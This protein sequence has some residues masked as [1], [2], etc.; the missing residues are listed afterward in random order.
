[1][2]K[3]LQMPIILAITDCQTDLHVISF[4]GC[5]ALNEAYRFDI[6]LLGDPLLDVRS[7]LHREAFLRFGERRSG[8]HGLRP[9]ST[10]GLA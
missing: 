10:A 7:L 3:D 8:V 4:T 5:D 9:E 1:M 2:R 6:W